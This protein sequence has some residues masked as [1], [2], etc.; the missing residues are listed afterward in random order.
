MRNNP[1]STLHFNPPSLL[2]KSETLNIL[3]AVPIAKCG[4]S[5]VP[6]TR[7]QL[8]ADSLCDEVPT[9]T[10]KVLCRDFARN[11]LATRKG[12]YTSITFGACIIVITYYW[13]Y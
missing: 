5:L 13:Y 11:A 7:N 4:S 3:R 8:R 9:V 6:G 12:Q 10:I 1:T 2:H